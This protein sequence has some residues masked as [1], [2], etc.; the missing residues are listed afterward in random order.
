M[1]EYLFILHFVGYKSPEN[2]ITKPKKQSVPEITQ[3]SKYFF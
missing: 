2:S 3:N 1:F